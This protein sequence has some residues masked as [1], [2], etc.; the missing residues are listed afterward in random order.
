MTQLTKARLSGRKQ[1]PSSAASKGDQSGG[2]EGGAGEGDGSE[3]EGGESEGGEIEGGEGDGEGRPPAPLPDLSTEEAALPLHFLALAAAAGLLS[4]LGALLLLVYMARRRLLKQATVV[5]KVDGIGKGQS[6]G[7][8][9]EGKGAEGR[10]APVAGKFLGC[11]PRPF[12]SLLTPGSLIRQV[13]GG[14]V[15]AINLPATTTAAPTPEEAAAATATTATSTPPLFPS[16]ALPTAPSV[17]PALPLPT[18]LRRRRSSAGHVY[19]V[20]EDDEEGEEG[21]DDDEGEAEDHSTWRAP[22][23]VSWSAATAA[24]TTTTATTAS[25]PP[26]VVTEA[27]GT[28]RGRTAPNAPMDSAPLSVALSKASLRGIVSS[29]VSSQVSS[30]ASSY[31]RRGVT[32]GLFARWG[33]SKDGDVASK[34]VHVASK[35]VLT[36]HCDDVASKEVPRHREELQDALDGSAPLAP[37]GGGGSGIGGPSGGRGRPG[38]RCTSRGE[39]ESTPRRTAGSEAKGSLSEQTL[40]GASLSG[41][42]LS[43]ASLDGGT[44]WLDLSHE[45]LTPRDLRSPRLAS[46]CALGAPWLAAEATAATNVKMEPPSAWPP[47]SQRIRMRSAGSE[48]RAAMMSFETPVQDEIMRSRG[49]SET[50]QARHRHGFEASSP[51]L[52]R[53]QKHDAYHSNV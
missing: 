14:L 17:V 4:C 37:S 30:E 24:A 15:A 38:Y 19:R 25:S 51:P 44:E 27:W 5:P 32:P 36:W 52:S 40:S 53:R 1:I 39:A 12:P 18:R 20:D 9:I 3:G 10:S 13:E 16:L 33:A 50:S 34:E 22:R 28:P 6:K 48:A 23:A 7:Q 41:A 35:E 21:E 45:L 31:S 47:P 29:Q 46:N 49:S 8:S 43:G 42:S 2:G 26:E 11:I